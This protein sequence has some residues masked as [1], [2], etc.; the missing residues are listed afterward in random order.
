MKRLNI[1]SSK[2]AFL[3]IA[4]VITSFMAMNCSYAGIVNDRS[5]HLSNGQSSVFSPGYVNAAKQKTMDIISQASQYKS[6][7]ENAAEAVK[8]KLS[9]DVAEDGANEVTPELKKKK[10]TNAEGTNKKTE[11]ISEELDIAADPLTYSVDVGSG[12]N[13]EYDSGGRLIAEVIN[14]ARHVYAGNFAAQNNQL[15]GY[16]GTMAIQNAM[17]NA[18]NGDVVLVS[19]G[20]YS[21]FAVTNGI[22]VYGGYSSDGSRDTSLST[23]TSTISAANITETTILSGFSVNGNG[24]LSRGIDVSNAGSELRIV[25]NE[26]KN[27]NVSGWGIIATQSSLVIENNKF[28]GVMSGIYSRG[29][30]HIMNNTFLNTGTGKAC[31]KIAGTMTGEGAVIE[32]NKFY[33]GS[34]GVSMYGIGHSTVQNNFFKD[35]YYGALESYGSLDSYR[36]GS[37][38]VDFMNNTVYDPD[39]RSYLGKM[40]VISSTQ[41]AIVN[42]ENNIITAS[43][44]SGYNSVKSGGTPLYAGVI[45]FKNNVLYYKSSTGTVGTFDPANTFMTENPLSISTGDVTIVDSSLAG[46]IGAQSY[47]ATI[48]TLPDTTTNANNMSTLYSSNANSGNL[49][50]ERQSNFDLGVFTSLASSMGKYESENLANIFKNLLADKSLLAQGMGGFVDPAMLAR[51]VK[52]ALNESALSVPATEVN[53][54]EMSVALALANIIKNPTEDQKMILDVVTALLKEVDKEGDESVSPELKKASDNLLQMVAAV[55]VAQAIPD[56]LKGG[57]VS[58]IKN[59]FA[60]LNAEQVRIMGQYQDATKSYYSEIMKDLKQNMET[61]QLESI[62]SNDISREELE[63]LPRSEIDK[64]IEKLR[65]AKDKS[66]ETEYMLQQEAKYR[67]AYLDPNK[68]ILEDRMKLMMKDFTRKLSKILEATKK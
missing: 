5:N 61:L 57:D 12:Q 47:D 26:I 33:G 65:K 27:I 2:P 55:L 58:N 68:K 60:D 32:Y 1:A 6:P 64:I 51:L 9:N 23:I 35:N 19:V 15:A 48:N 45:N 66:F 18:Q 42:A 7:I 30:A 67:K 46:K 40:A 14:G 62:I 17:A 16:T 24:T 29:S 54:Q 53:S 11:S 50:L 31:V 41:G 21:G 28:S 52:N 39:S 37:C 8:N 13:K 34:W 56:L 49:Q 22:K 10:G 63:K 43:I 3:L 36:A 25:G 4:M 44:I 59:I 20:T 38:V